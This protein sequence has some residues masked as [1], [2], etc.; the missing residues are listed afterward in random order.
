MPIRLAQIP[1]ICRM[2]PL[3]GIQPGV[4]WR[5]G[6]SRNSEQWGEGVERVEPPVEAERELIE[7]GLQML[8]AD[9]MVGATKP[10][11][12]VAE[13]E[14]DDRQKLFGHLGVTTFGKGV[15]IK[16]APPQAAIGTPIVGD[17][18]RPRHNGA[19]DEAT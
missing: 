9:A 6:R 2:L 12:Q 19:F 5:L 10:V 4:S 7:V 14:V 1:T 3:A 13:D 16:A 17:D 15:V 11:L 18:P 8:S